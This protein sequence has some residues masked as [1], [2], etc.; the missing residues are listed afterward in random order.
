MAANRPAERL[1]QI[2]A[3]GLIGTAIDGAETLAERLRQAIAEAPVVLDSGEGIAVTISIGV[4]G[5]RPGDTELEGM[6]RRA[7]AALYR[8]KA[9]GRNRVEVEDAL[10]LPLPPAA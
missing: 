7:D 9:R 8:A 3:N 5:Y 2:R 10:A 6:V 1:F 4:A